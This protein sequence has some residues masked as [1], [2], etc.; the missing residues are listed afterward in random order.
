MHYSVDPVRAQIHWAEY[1]LPKKK[2]RRWK[3]EWEEGKGQR[4]ENE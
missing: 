3:E 4:G 1:L 2:R